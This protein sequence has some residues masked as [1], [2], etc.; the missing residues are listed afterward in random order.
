MFSVPFLPYCFLVVLVLY[1]KSGTS[2][3]N[4]ERVESKGGQQSETIIQV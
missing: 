3:Q 2:S 4:W 1:H